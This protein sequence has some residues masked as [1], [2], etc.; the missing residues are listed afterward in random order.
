LRDRGLTAPAAER[1]TVGRVDVPLDDRLPVP[2]TVLVRQHRGK[3]VRV[4]VLDHGFECEGLVY[5][6]LS[7]VA[8]AVTGCHWNGYHFFNLRVGKDAR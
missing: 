7:A 5:R 2:G 6:S 1:T 3:Q 4:T 8:R